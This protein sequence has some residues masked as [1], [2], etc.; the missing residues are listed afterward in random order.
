VV[1]PVR[2][3]K[4]Q[5]EFRPMAEGI[6]SPLNLLLNNLQ[7]CQP[8]QHI[9]H[10]PS[11]TSSHVYASGTSTCS[12]LHDVAT[13]PISFLTKLPFQLVK[14]LSRRFCQRPA[15]RCL[16]AA[17]RS[18]ADKSRRERC[19]HRYSVRLLRLRWQLTSDSMTQRRKGTTT[20]LTKPRR[21][22]CSVKLPP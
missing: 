2:S 17:N 5:G 12:L 14:A 9:H 10:C 7:A 11:F 22:T 3:T 13:I 8:G 18:S 19:V 1:W 4:L 16:E 6:R 20:R 15:R 21:G